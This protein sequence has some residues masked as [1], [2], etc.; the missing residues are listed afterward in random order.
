MLEI[1]GT[2]IAVLINFLLLIWLLNY[3]LYKPINKI[4]SERKEY[5]ESTLKAANEKQ[6]DADALKA[7]YEGNIK[8]AK[9]ESQKIINRASVLVEKMKLEAFESAKVDGDFIRKRAEK[10]AEDIKRQALVAAKKDFAKIVCNAAGRFMK[11]NID[12]K[13]HKVLI[14]DMFSEANRA[15]LN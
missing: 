5:I 10:E 7:E 2:L 3:F 11:K 9:A 8:N 14:D 12:E 15:D 13:S 6:R 1:N 4:L